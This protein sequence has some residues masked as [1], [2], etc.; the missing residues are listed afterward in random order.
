[1]GL[2]IC[3][4]PL[5]TIFYSIV[6]NHPLLLCSMISGAESQPMKPNQILQC[7]ARPGYYTKMNNVTIW[8]QQLFMLLSI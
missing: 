4:E 6:Q 7:P 1:M 2:V 3:N 8:G 5:E